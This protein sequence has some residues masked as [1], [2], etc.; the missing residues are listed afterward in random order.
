MSDLLDHRGVGHASL[1]RPADAWPSYTTVLRTLPTIRRMKIRSTSPLIALLSAAAFVV[2]LPATAAQAAGDTAGEKVSQGAERAGNAVSRGAHAAASG[3]QRGVH[4]A[5]NG[6][7]RGAQA[8][9]NGLKRAAE[10]TERG[11]KRAVQATARGIERGA[12]A[13]GRA[14][15]KVAEKIG[16]ADE[17]APARDR[18]PGS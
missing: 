5:A 3:V 14:A 6:V 16:L 11:V 1:R 9:E 7:E 18:S 13:T 12:E 15:R 8:T 10:A 2:A 4:A 17:P